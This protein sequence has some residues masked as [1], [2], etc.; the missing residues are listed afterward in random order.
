MKETGAMLRLPGRYYRTLP[1]DD[2]GYETE[3]LELAVE[4]TAFIAMHCWDI[5]CEG[6]PEVDPQY[7]VGMG[8]VENFAEAE[9]IMV[10]VIRPAMDAARAARLTVCHVESPTIAAKHPE[11]Q[12]EIDAVGEAVAGPDEVVEGWREGIL[13]RSHGRDYATLSPYARM[14]RAKVVAPLAGEIYAYQTGQLDRLLRRRGIEN[15]IYTGF[16]TDM[17]VLNA[18]G[19]IALMAPLGYRVFLMR[20]G[21]LGVE[22]PDTF[23]QRIATR[24]ATR[25]FECHYGDT[26]TLA[27]FIEACEGVS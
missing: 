27:D 19:G 18:G 7:C 17:C 26:I 20:D 13:A 4:K 12:E 9:R 16:A 22:L 10:E 24:W 15:L 6:G 14:D 21:T 25:Y 23:E 11:A 3:M 2:T 5:G 1:I 8:F